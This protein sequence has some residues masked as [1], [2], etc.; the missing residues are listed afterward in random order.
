MRVSEVDRGALEAGFSSAKKE[1]LLT[2]KRSGSVSL[3]DLA[4]GLGLSKMA[5]LKHLNGLETRG[6]VE[7]SSRPSGRGRP[8]AFFALTNRSA[9]LFPE[10]YTHM[11]LCALRFIEEK[12]GREAIVRLLEQR[13]Q[14]VL[15]TNR[16]RVPD[17]GLRE[18]V[19]ALAEIRDEGGYM[20]EVGRTGKNTVEM[21]EHNC[22]IMAVAEAYPEACGIE[23]AMFQKLLRAD[24]ETSHRV[25]AGDPV[26]RFLIR[27]RAA[28]VPP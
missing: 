21:L 19:S 23:R 7:R 20:A 1:I 18:K 16:R 15:D 12:L 3:G 22:P 5:T 13:A 28:S 10:A 17:A 24:V 26:C 6:L 9:G 14:E 4:R 27:G 2:L 25:V 11:T 8:R